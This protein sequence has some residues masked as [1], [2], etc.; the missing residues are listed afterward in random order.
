MAL[1]EV[2]TVLEMSG[3]ELVCEGGNLVSESYFLM[4]QAFSLASGETRCKL[5]G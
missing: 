2:M 3:L 1:Q 4:N 5:T